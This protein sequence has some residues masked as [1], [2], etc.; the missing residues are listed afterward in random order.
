MAHGVLLG[1]NRILTTRK[2]A[3]IVELNNDIG[4]KSLASIAQVLTMRQITGSYCF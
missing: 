1:N 3:A 2:G 4:Q